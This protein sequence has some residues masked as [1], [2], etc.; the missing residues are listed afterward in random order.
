MDTIIVTTGA[1]MTPLTS[2][3]FL[4]TLAVAVL[5]AIWLA[6]GAPVIG[7]RPK[8][9]GWA[10]RHGSQSVP[11]GVTGAAPQQAGAA[12]SRP[13]DQES[14]GSEGVGGDRAAS[15]P[16]RAG[17]NSHV[18]GERSGHPCC[19]HCWHDY[20]EQECESCRRVAERPR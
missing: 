11:G 20:C 2:W 18:K 14:A 8:D 6:A 17:R 7:E 1:G 4:I 15:H 16:G 9:R 12:H 13:S 19:A 5:T 3:A 10:G